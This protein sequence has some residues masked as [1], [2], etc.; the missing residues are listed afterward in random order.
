MIYD[1]HRYRQVARLDDLEL[2]QQEQQVK[3]ASVRAVWADENGRFPL[4]QGANGDFRDVNTMRSFT[5]QTVRDAFP[6]LEQQDALQRILLAARGVSSG[7]DRL[8]ELIPETPA[9]VW[10]DAV[11]LDGL[12]RKYIPRPSYRNLLLG[13]AYDEHGN[14][15]PVTG[16]MDQMIHL[17]IG[18]GSGWGKSNFENV[19]ARQLQQSVDDC[20]LVLIDFAGTTLLPMEKSDRVL[21]PMVDNH[22]MA[23]EVF[24]RIGKELE[25][26][27]ELFVTYPGAQNLTQYNQASG[28]QLLPWYVLIDET[29]ALMRQRAIRTMFI[30]ICERSRKFG[31]GFI[32]CGTTWH[33]STV[34][35]AARGNFSTRASVHASRVTSQIILEDGCASMLDKQ[36]R[37]MLIM[38]GRQMQ[39][40]LIPEGAFDV[41]EGSGPLQPLRIHNTDPAFVD[42]V[43]EVWNGLD[44]RKSA[45]AV[46]RAMGKAA[47]G[48]VFYDVRDALERLGLV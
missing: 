34:P 7:A 26:R 8:P 24:H 1:I 4:L 48:S 2:D 31:I 23:K 15:Q 17:M 45:S 19:I 22:A 28:D 37:G 9:F 44:G 35:E 43:L 42:Q 30:D 36:G 29:P 47:G 11:P 27:R 6:I 33:A 16:D 18:G 20:R 3:L 21:F 13:V 40:I 5:I 41:V 14:E 32:A 10:P 46:C 25:R 38:P 39:E 12:L